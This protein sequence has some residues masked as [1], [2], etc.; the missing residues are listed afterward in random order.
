VVVALV[1]LGRSRAVGGVQTLVWAALI[2]LVPILGAVAWLV[3][4]RRVGQP[5]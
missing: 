2:V 5:A 4:G 3:A 1:S